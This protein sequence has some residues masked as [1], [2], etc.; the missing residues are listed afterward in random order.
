MTAATLD[1]EYAEAWI[2]T[3]RDGAYPLGPMR[4]G[5]GW[6]SETNVCRGAESNTDHIYFLQWKRR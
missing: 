3:P 6:V 4:D 5:L 2:W 1:A